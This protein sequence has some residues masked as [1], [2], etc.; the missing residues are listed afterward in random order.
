MYNSIFIIALN[1]GAINTIHYI[2]RRLLAD[3][4]FM[5]E[6]GN[7]ENESVTLPVF[8]LT[9]D[10]RDLEDAFHGSG[11]TVADFMPRD[12]IRQEVAGF[13]AFT[14]IAF[15]MSHEFRHLHAGH[16]DYVLN[17][18]R[19]TSRLDE[20][21]AT[22]INELTFVGDPRIALKRQALEMDADSAATFHLFSHWGWIY[23]QTRGMSPGLWQWSDREL[24]LSIIYLSCAGL[25][26][27]LDSEANPPFGE[28]NKQYHP[29]AA[30][31][32]FIVRAS[33]E[34][35]LQAEG[36]GMFGMDTKL[37]GIKL[38]H[39]LERGIVQ[40]VWGCTFEE[41]YARLVWSPVGINYI[42]ELETTA[43][44]MDPVIRQYAYAKIHDA[45]ILGLVW[46]REPSVPKRR[47]ETTPSHRCPSNQNPLYFVEVDLVAGAVIE[48]GRLRAI[49]GWRSAGRARWCRRLPGRR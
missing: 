1:K 33:A 7:G 47:T 36:K 24:F 35:Y 4:A 27:I 32:R 2:F 45:S 46:M 5:P 44:A 20:S 25:F 18:M 16:L 34:T 6:I 13:M 28:W 41:D 43:K 29:P 10:Y 12:P 11:L 39:V 3:R 9:G 22:S 38:A 8:T 30:I 15:L 17:R 19:L 21:N 23:Q 31:R 14:A 26:R 40:K 37:P 49:R 48:L 42:K